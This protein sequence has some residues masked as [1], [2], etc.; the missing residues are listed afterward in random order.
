M[1]GSPARRSHGREIAAHPVGSRVKA[2]SARTAAWAPMKKSGSGERRFPPRR[3]YATNAFPQEGCLPWNFVL[4][5]YRARQRLIRISSTRREWIDTSAKM[6]GVDHKLAGMRLA[7]SADLPRPS[8]HRHG[9]R[10][11]MS[12]RI[13]RVDQDRR[14]SPLVSAMISSVVILIVA[15]PLRRSNAAATSRSRGVTAPPLFARRRWTPASSWTNSTSVPGKN[16]DRRR[17]RLG[18]GDL[19]FLGHTH[20]VCSTHQLHELIGRHADVDDAGHS[21]EICGKFVLGPCHP[22]ARRRLGYNDTPASFGELHLGPGPDFLDGVEC[23]SGIVTWPL[24]VTRIS[25]SFILTI[26]SKK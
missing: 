17:I 3:R 6:I 15:L 23:A 14:H 12:S 20:S 8:A 5:E 2:R 4:A 19:P 10:S 18:N 21:I 11:T 24:D 9:S 16:P 7:R 25:P 22:V 13:A 26:P 1:D